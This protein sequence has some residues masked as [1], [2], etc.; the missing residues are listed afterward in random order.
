[1]ELELDDGDVAEESSPVQVDDEHRDDDAV[2]RRDRHR[3]RAQ[4]AGAPNLT[5][6]GRNSM[7]TFCPKICPVTFV[8]L[9]LVAT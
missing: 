1:M 7:D 9:S 4:A 3:D 8:N 6:Q 5:L 2:L